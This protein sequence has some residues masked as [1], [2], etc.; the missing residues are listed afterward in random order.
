MPKTDYVRGIEMKRLG[1]RADESKSN[2]ISLVISHVRTRLCI[3]QGSS[4]VS[5]RNCFGRWNQGSFGTTLMA[6]VVTLVDS[7]V[8]FH[9]VYR[10]C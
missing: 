5:S 6:V 9:R 7:V 10:V 1:F 3:E 2:V 8:V 4:W